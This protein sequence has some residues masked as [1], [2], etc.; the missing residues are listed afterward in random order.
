MILH[1]SCFGDKT[2]HFTD[3]IVTLHNTRYSKH[4][5]EAEQN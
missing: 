4:S 2:P 1:V 5:L 3:T